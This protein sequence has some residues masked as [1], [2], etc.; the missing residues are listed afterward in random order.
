MSIKIRRAEK[1]DIPRVLELI[2]ELAI[3]EREPNAVVINE[4]ELIRDGFGSNP[5]YGLFVGEDEAQII[6]GIALYYFRYSTWNGKVL[7]LEDLIVT[8]QERGKGYGRDLLNAILEEADK[9]NCRLCTW[10]V[11]DWNEPSIAFYKN[12]GADL[13]EGWIN[14]TVKKEQ[15]KSIYSS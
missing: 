7:Y 15:Y 14:C 5:A 3:Y 6:V 1:K 13:D 2:K 11:L 9:Q 4:D 8:E 12:I 10:Q